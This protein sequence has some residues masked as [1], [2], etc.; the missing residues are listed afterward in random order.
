MVLYQGTT[1]VSDPRWMKHWG[2]PSIERLLLDGWDPTKPKLHAA[3]FVSYQATTSVVPKK[4]LHQGTTSV[5]PK[6]PNKGAGFS[7]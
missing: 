7:P 1:G 5:V 4:V 2:A 3:G 6:K